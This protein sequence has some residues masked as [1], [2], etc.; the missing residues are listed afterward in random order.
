MM[1]VI[2]SFSFVRYLIPVSVYR[3]GEDDNKLDV[4]PVA[5]VLLG[6]LGL[7]VGL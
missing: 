2:L 4:I 6:D 5:I 3:E 1:N 7:D